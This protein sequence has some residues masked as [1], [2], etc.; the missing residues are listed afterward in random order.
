MPQCECCPRQQQRQR[1]LAR[2]TAE[3]VL[4]LAEVLGDLAVEV[5]ALHYPELLTK[6]CR[7]THRL[8]EMVDLEDALTADLPE[9]K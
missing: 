4:I 5:E 6:I 1:E 3:A 2:E 8:K 7:A 9:R